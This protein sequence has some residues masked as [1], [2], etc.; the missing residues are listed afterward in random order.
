M[1]ISHKL[2]VS[3]MSENRLLIIEEKL[4]ILAERAARDQTRG[5]RIPLRRIYA[6]FFA[7]TGIHDRGCT[8]SHHL[9]SMPFDF[10]FPQSLGN[11]AQ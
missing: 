5:H 4:Y 1:N 11:P 2:E 9:G 6:G 7:R 3:V 8:R 10:D